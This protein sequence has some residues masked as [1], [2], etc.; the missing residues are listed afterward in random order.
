MR[1]MFEPPVHE[2]AV[3]SVNGKRAGA[4][5]TTPFE[6]DV[7]GPEEA[8]YHPVEADER[9]RFASDPANQA[10]RKIHAGPTTTA[11][12]NPR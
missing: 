9:S 7:T 4:I 3:V 1:A 10:L 2:A 5:W 8:P 11:K 12:G 6:V